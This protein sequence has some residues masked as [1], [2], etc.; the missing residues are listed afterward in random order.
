MFACDARLVSD[1]EIPGFVD[2]L[3]DAGLV[4]LCAWGPGCERMHDLADRA[5]VRHESKTGL[6]RPTM[7][8][9]HVGGE[10]DDVLWFLLNAAS[11]DEA[12]ANTCGSNLIVTISNIKW[13]REVLNWLNRSC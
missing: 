12:Y 7:T 10:L 4:D 9:W 13:E 6:E 1:V 2:A 3:L 5:P 8:T 11:P